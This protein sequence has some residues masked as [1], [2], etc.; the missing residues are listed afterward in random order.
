MFNWMKRI[1]NS[2]TKF[3][4]PLPL[5]FDL[6]GYIH[7]HTAMTPLYP[8]FPCSVSVFFS[9]NQKSTWRFSREKWKRKNDTL[10][11]AFSI[12]LNE[13][14]WYLS[15]SFSFWVG[16][17]WKSFIH[18]MGV[19]FFT[20]IG[21]CKCKKKKFFLEG[22]LLFMKHK[23][24]LCNPTPRKFLN[25]FFQLQNRPKFVEPSKM[26]RFEI[27]FF[28]SSTRLEPTRR[29][30]KVR[31]SNPNI[32]SKFDIGFEIRFECSRF[33]GTGRY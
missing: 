18:Q 17:F 31:I 6:L 10:L 32:G 14:P 26:P 4:W 27:E 9:L 29:D 30:S 25:R 12:T 15:F 16:C 28:E 2:L 7:K 23:N 21:N 33:D 20:I 3:F 13:H 11:C 22:K 5:C 8:R 19:T 1:F 24:Q